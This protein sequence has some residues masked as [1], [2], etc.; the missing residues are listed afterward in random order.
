[1]FLDLLCLMSQS[2]DNMHELLTGCSIQSW[3]P[4]SRV[5]YADGSSTNHWYYGVDHTSHCRPRSATWTMLELTITFSL[6]LNVEC[7]TRLWQ[8]TDLTSHFARGL[9]ACWAGFLK[10]V[11]LHAVRSRMRLYGHPRLCTR[12]YNSDQSW[13]FWTCSRE[14]L[15]CLPGKDTD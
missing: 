11:A 3:L 7:I 15:L 13:A 8:R 1:M 12:H 9:M 4:V 2:W 14:H 10:C 6:C 5:H